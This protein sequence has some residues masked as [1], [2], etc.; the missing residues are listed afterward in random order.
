MKH[1]G[2]PKYAKEQVFCIILESGFM[3]LFRKEM[4]N[5]KL[6]NHSISWLSKKALT[7]RAQRTPNLKKRLAISITKLSVID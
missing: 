7:L 1:I 3:M 4:L 2:I 5:K 6:A